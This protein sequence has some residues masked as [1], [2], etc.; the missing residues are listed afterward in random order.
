M[1]KSFAE[2]MKEQELESFKKKIVFDNTFDDSELNFQSQMEEALVL[3]LI[4]SQITNNHFS[5]D[6]FFD[7]EDLNNVDI[8]EMYFDE[9]KDLQLEE[10][11]KIA[12]RLQN[13]EREKYRSSNP[14]NKEMT[15]IEKKM[16]YLNLGVDDPDYKKE[17]KIDEEFQ[18]YYETVEPRVNGDDEENY[19]FDDAQKKKIK[20]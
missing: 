16:Y 17:L 11:E 3:S 1:D 5:E 9:V 2:I 4:K 8:N 18:K 15:E 6:M 13:I 7:V 19:V 10:D 14:N 12:L 20:K